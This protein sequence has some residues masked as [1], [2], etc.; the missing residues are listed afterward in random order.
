MGT[1]PTVANTATTTHRRFML[2]ILHRMEE[3]LITDI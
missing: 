1:I 2:A 3:D